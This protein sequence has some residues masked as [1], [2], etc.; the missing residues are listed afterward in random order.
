M[1]LLTENSVIV[2]AHK[3]GHVKNEPSQDFVTIEGQRLLIET[4]PE[5]R[6]I[7]GCPNYGPTIKP[8]SNT[9]KVKVGYSELLTVN[10][11]AICL[12]TLNGLTDGTP[13]GVVVYQVADVQQNFVSEVK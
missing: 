5:G 10:G 13:P 6:S 9:L 7:S 3:M 8:C 12:D 4:D 2:C 11:K 1:F